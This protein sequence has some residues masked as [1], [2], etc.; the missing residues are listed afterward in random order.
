MGKENGMWRNRSVHPTS[1]QP[2]PRELTLLWGRG[3]SSSPTQACLEGNNDWMVGG[4]GR[5]DNGQGAAL[6]LWGQKGG[7][8]CQLVVPWPLP[9]AQSPGFSTSLAL[10][11]FH[12]APDL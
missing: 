3:F 5:T 1:R 11:F 9:P 6:E 8:R 2:S 7:L 12:P 10:G 4:V